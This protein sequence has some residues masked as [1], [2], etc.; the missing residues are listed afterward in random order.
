M[1]N[2]LGMEDGRRVV[3]LRRGAANWLKVK[4]R[5]TSQPTNSKFRSSNPHA[6]SCFTPVDEQFIEPT[7]KT[8]TGANKRK[9]AA[10]PDSV[11][12]AAW[13]IIHAAADASEGDLLKIL[14]FVESVFGVLRRMA[15]PGVP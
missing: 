4:L 14:Q 12:A 5:R 10:L 1:G 7:S 11:G 9:A 2:E 13:Q 8:K 15:A 3:H 6:A